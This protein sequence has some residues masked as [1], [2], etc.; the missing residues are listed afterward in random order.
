[1]GQTKENSIGIINIE[2][3][4]QTVFF[5]N[6]WIES[7]IFLEKEKIVNLSFSFLAS[8]ES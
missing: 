6:R 4:M 1:M 8:I 3:F 7:F 2:G 5:R